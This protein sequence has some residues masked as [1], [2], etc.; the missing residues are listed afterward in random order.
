MPDGETLLGELHAAMSSGAVG[1]GFSVNEA[2]VY[3]K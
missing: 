1:S 3:I 2:T